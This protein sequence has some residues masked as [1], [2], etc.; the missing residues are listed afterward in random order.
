MDNLAIYNGT[1]DG[2]QFILRKKD[3]DRKIVKRGETWKDFLFDSY[4]FKAVKNIGS[5]Y[6]S[7]YKEILFEEIHNFYIANHGHVINNEGEIL[8]SEYIKSGIERYR[9]RFR[10]RIRRF[11]R[12]SNIT[13]YLK[14]E[15]YFTTITYSDKIFN[16]EDEFKNTLL[17]YMQNKSVRNNWKYMGTF[18]RGDDNSRLHW[19]GL[20][21]IP[22]KEICGTINKKK[23]WSD[24]S[25]KSVDRY[26]H[27]DIANKFG[28][29]DFQLLPDFEI[30]NGNVIDYCTKYVYKQGL[31]MHY[32]RGI[33]TSFIIE[34]EDDVIGVAVDLFGEA[35]IADMY[36]YERNRGCLMWIT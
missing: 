25:Y 22:R 8:D 11:V 15:M 16:S 27:S 33:P 19:H 1:Y 26:E 21:Y 13:A 3:D 5:K 36:F 14:Q 24:K 2:S 28:M 10:S 23:Q 18:E 9:N 29:N 31:K 20:I 30:N 4:Y 34:S 12:K 32:S 17:K 6:Q 35:F 7:N